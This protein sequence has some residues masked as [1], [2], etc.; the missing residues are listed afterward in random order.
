MSWVSD[1]RTIIAFDE[2]VLPP[3]GTYA[4]ELDLS[5]HNGCDIIEQIAWLVRSL[6]APYEIRANDQAISPDEIGRHHTRLTVW[7]NDRSN[8]DFLLLVHE[9]GVD[10]VRSYP[11]R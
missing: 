5:G 2:G 3:A 6:R 8:A 1:A 9:L 7:T 4:F 11:E 10:V